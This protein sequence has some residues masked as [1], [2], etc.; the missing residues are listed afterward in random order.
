MSAYH[1]QLWYKHLVCI[2]SVYTAFERPVCD[3]A[4]SVLAALER[5]MCD[6]VTSVSVTFEQ[7]M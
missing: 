1:L 4:T 6:S 3:N 7:H 5:G 2:T